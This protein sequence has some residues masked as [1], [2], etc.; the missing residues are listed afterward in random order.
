MDI[1]DFNRAGVESFYCLQPVVV[2]PFENKY[3]LIDWQ[4]D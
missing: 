3:E 4:R 1:K 2:K